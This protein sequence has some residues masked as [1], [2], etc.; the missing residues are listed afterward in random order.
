MFWSRPELAF[1]PT[2]EMAASVVTAQPTVRKTLTFLLPAQYTTETAPIPTDIRVKLSE[3]L[4]QTV[5]VY[6]FTC[7]AH[8]RCLIHVLGCGG[9]L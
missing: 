3:R 6:R 7:E 9:W 5:A 2:A 4:P 1:E 8:P